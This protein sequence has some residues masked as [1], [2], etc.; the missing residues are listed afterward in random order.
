[1]WYPE[2]ALYGA[3]G[4]ISG[5]HIGNGGSQ[6]RI[7]ST[8]LIRCQTEEEAHEEFFKFAKIYINQN[9]LGNASDD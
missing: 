4:T 8:P 2:Q 9:E 6:N 7:F 5:I 3:Q 1:M